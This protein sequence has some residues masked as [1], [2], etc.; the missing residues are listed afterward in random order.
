MERE[1]GKRKTILKELLECPECNYKTLIYDESD[2][3]WK[4]AACGKSFDSQSIQDY[5]SEREYEISYQGR[6]DW[7][8]D[9]ADAME[10]PHNSHLW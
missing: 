9:L 7:E 3:I 2:M 4:C 6:E 10:D 1:L 8:A 5:I